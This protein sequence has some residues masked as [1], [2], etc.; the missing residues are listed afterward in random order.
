MFENYRHQIRVHTDFEFVISGKAIYFAKYVCNNKILVIELPCMNFDFSNEK[1]IPS[2]IEIGCYFLD[3]LD[4]EYPKDFEA[5][6]ASQDSALLLYRTSIKQIEDEFIRNL[7]R[8]FENVYSK[9]IYKA[10]LENLR[11]SDTDLEKTLALCTDTSSLERDI[12]E[13]IK[14][15]SRDKRL[16]FSEEATTKTMIFD[17][18]DGSENKK[19]LVIEKL[20]E[21][22]SEKSEKSD[23]DKFD[24]QIFE[25]I[26]E[27]LLEVYFKRVKEK[28]LYVEEKVDKTKL[29]RYIDHPYILEFYQGKSRPVMSLSRWI[30]INFSLI[31]LTSR[32]L[33]RSISR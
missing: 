7:K 21:H 12:T 13:T 29:K 23:K 28:N 9:N 26:F 10:C 17:E 4:I 15:L 22:P 27:G 25:N 8:N 5:L 24:I 11:P 3:I 32:T 18:L 1:R 19:I 30:E 33:W 20:V 14:I 16:D 6:R 2:K 31:S